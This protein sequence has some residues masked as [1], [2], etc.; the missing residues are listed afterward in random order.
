MKQHKIDTKQ[1]L[2]DWLITY[3]PYSDLFQMYDNLGFKKTDVLEKKA[4]DFKIY[5]SKKTYLP[6]FFE[7]RNVY[8]KFGVDFDNMVKL[9]IIKLIE[10]ILSKYV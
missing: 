4:K 1:L 8:G 10:P 5:I 3:D 9:D 6:V 2:K 7:I